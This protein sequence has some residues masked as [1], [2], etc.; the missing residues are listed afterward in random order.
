MRILIVDDSRG[1]RLLMTKVI[2]QAGFGAH[3][4]EEAGSGTEALRLIE[5]SPP[6]LVISDWNMPEMNGAGLL[7]ALKEKNLRVKMGLVTSDSAPGV[8]T[9]A[10]AGG[11]CFI[12]Q[13]A[14]FNAELCQKLLAPLLS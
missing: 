3:T 8:K 1:M 14:Q 12:V 2:K 4:F 11:A 7:N 9:Q 5:T 13:K 6:D 10:E